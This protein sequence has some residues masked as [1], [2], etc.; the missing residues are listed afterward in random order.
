MATK[1]RSELLQECATQAD[2][3]YTTFGRLLYENIQSGGIAYYFEPDN[4]ALMAQAKRLVKDIAAEKISDRK[5]KVT[6]VKTVRREVPAKAPV[7]SPVKISA[8]PLVKPPVKAA[9]V[10]L[11]VRPVPKAPKNQVVAVLKGV[12]HVLMSEFKGHDVPAELPVVKLPEM[13]APVE[14]VIDTAAVAKEFVKKS[15]G[16]NMRG[17]LEPYTQLI[18]ELH[19]SRNKILDIQKDLNDCISTGLLHTTGEQTADHQAEVN[20]KIQSI[21]VL[22]GQEREE[23]KRIMENKRQFFADNPEADTWKPEEVFLEKMQQ[24]VALTTRRV[25]DL[26]AEVVVLFKHISAGFEN[27]LSQTRESIRAPREVV[28][29]E[30]RSHE[31]APSLLVD[32]QFETFEEEPLP[33]AAVEAVEED[34]PAEEPVSEDANVETA[35]DETTDDET[36]DDETTDDEAGDYGLLE[37]A[38]RK[39][40]GDNISDDEKVAVLHTVFRNAPKRAVPFLYE[41]IR[42]SDIYFQR[43]TLSLL[44]ALDYPTMVDLYRRFITDVNS[45]LRLQGMMGLIKLGSDEAKHVLVSAIRDHDAHVRRFIVNHLDHTAGEPEATAIARLSGDIDD[46]VARVAI[47][48]LAMM[49]N[50]FAFVTLVPKLESASARVCKEAI[51]A[52][53]LITGTDLGYNYTATH[54]ERKRQAKPWNDLARKSYTQPRLLRELRQQSLGGQPKVEASAVK[55]DAKPQVK[56]P[57]VKVLKPKRA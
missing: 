36:T 19:V 35:D 40:V 12:T 13:P 34:I 57:V 5:A 37:T 7:K 52:L 11:T 53:L 31:Q 20:R 45:S 23:I 27:D 17:K 55:A 8:K 49:G 1:K 46:G 48:K 22:L 2:S 33:E 28:V 44:T 38:A 50:H 29:R 32:K 18:V 14:A 4:A 39:L 43:R 26:V 24:E 42:E 25:D 6:P 15:A 54:A 30:I 10:K 56:A 47:R 41:L 3:L 16:M 21:T 51:D 9:P